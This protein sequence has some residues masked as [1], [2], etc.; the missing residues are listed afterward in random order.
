MS[1]PPLL[2]VIARKPN[3]RSAIFTSVGRY[4]V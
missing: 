3:R 1:H 4:W 2:T